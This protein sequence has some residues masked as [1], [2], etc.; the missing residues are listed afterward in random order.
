VT[1]PELEIANRRWNRFQSRWI[2]RHRSRFNAE[3]I[4]RHEASPGSRGPPP[5]VRLFHGRLSVLMKPLSP[6][7]GGYGA[8]CFRA[9]TTVPD[10][11]INVSAFSAGMVLV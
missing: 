11:S 6:A 10:H 8:I 9:F 4:L 1:S 7:D 3:R 5:S 2:V